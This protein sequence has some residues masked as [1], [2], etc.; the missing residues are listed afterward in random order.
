MMLWCG[1]NL[2]CSHESFINKNVALKA[3]LPWGADKR[4]KEENVQVSLVSPLYFPRK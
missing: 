1:V 4:V 2:G 3:S